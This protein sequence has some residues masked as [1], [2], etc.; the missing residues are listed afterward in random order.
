MLLLQKLLY[1]HKLGIL[2]N[3]GVDGDYDQIFL[4]LVD[5]KVDAKLF[6]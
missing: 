1:V 2:E 6:H 5:V 3:I 4:S